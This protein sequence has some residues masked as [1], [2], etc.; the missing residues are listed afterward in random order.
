MNRGLVGHCLP[1]EEV[2]NVV[3]HP[4]LDGSETKNANMEFKTLRK[5]P[6]PAVCRGEIIRAQLV[7]CMV[8]KP[9]DCPHALAY[10]CGFFCRHPERF[11]IAARTAE[12]G[13]DRNPGT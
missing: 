4:T 5:L 8:E 1:R 11:E 7:E 6:D 12:V 3:W 10:G 9:E 2:N 13:E